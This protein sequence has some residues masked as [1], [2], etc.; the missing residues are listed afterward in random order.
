MPS[1]L[2]ILAFIFDPERSKPSPPI[3]A[4]SKLSINPSQK[5]QSKASLLVLLIFILF[6]EILLLIIFN[7]SSAIEF[8]IYKLFQTIQYIILLIL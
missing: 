1:A 8:L 5:S 2:F 3:L 6:K 7:A 4:N